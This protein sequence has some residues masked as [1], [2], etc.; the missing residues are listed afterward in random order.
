MIFKSSTLAMLIG[1]ALANTAH[2]EQAQDTNNKLSTYQHGSTQAQTDQQSSFAKAHE[3][4]GVYL[5]ILSE[6][7][8]LDSTYS[9]QGS[10]RSEVVAVIEQQQ[11]DIM[12]AIRNLDANAVLTRKARLTENALYV[13]MTHEAAK[14]IRE[15][16]R[17]ILAELLNEEPNYTAEDEFARF[18]FLN[19]K[20]AGDAVT[21]AII[22][23]GID[24]THA[25][26]GGEGTVEAYEQAWA[27][28]HNAWDG[29]PTDTVIGGLDFG[30]EGY[31]YID[32]NPLEMAGDPNVESGA[33]PSGTVIASQILEQAPDAKILSYKTYD[34]SHAYFYP[35]L[36][37]IV[38]P[39]QDGDIS[40]RP[41]VI[42]MNAWGNNAFYVE[43]DTQGSQPTRD[44]G[45]VRRL[46]ATGSLLVV[47][48]GQTYYDQYFNLAWRGAVPEALT[49][50][51]VSVDGETMQLSDFTPAGPVRGG[52]L[53]KPE[54]VG[55]GE[56]I[57][58]PLAGSGADNLMVSPHSSYAAGY[59]A[60]TAARILAQ[61][62]QLSPIEAKALVANTANAE[63]IVGNTAY[64]EEFDVHTHKL[65]EVPFMGTGMVDGE[66]AVTANAVAFESSSYQPGLAFGFV[67]TATKTSV[68]RYVTLKNL[69]H[70]VQSYTIS[71]MVN[72][73]KTNNAAVSFVYPEVVN[74]PGNRSVS[75]PVTM[76]LD[77]SKLATDPLMST[78]DFTIE[79]WSKASVNG[80]L[81]FTSTKHNAAD[82]AMAWQV[83]PKS[84]A[85]LSK[86]NFGITTRLPYDGG[87][88]VE[89]SNS[90][91]EWIESSL[92]DVTNNTAQ[93]RVLHTLPS[94][95]TIPVKEP[96]KAGGQ[97]HLYKRMG[98]TIS[99]DD[100]CESNAMLSMAVQMFD[101]FDVPVAEHFDKAGHVLSYFSIYSEAITEQYADDPFALDRSATDADKLAYFEIITVDSGLP[102]LKY[103]DYSLEFRW[104]DP[105]YRVKY[106]EFPVDV[107]IGDDT[108]VG[109]ICVEDLYH[110]DYQSVDAF[111]GNLG[112]QFASDRDAQS[113]VSGNVI[114]YN[115]MINGQYFEEIVDHTGETGYPNWWDTWT[116]CAAKSWDP[117][118]CIENKSTLLA[119]TGKIATLDDEGEALSWSNR[120]E[121]APGETV[122][123]S[124]GASLQC[125]PNVVSTGIWVTHEDCPEGVMIF[126]TGND[127]FYMSGATFGYD[128]TVIEGQSFIVYENAENG[129][130]VGKV[131]MNSR[132]F[133]Q[134]ETADGE[135]YLVNAIPG[136]PFSVAI[137]GTISVANAD[138]INYEDNTSFTLKL[139]ADYVNRDSKLVEVTVI[140]NN[141]NDVAPMQVKLTD[142]IITRVGDTVNVDLNG[143]FVDVEGDGVAYYSD[144][145]PQGL[146]ISASGVIS[147]SAEIAGNYDATIVATDGANEATA[148]VT[149]EVAQS[150]QGS[151]K[152]QEQ[153]QEEIAEESDDSS[154]GSTSFVFALLTLFGL[155]S[156]RVYK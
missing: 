55:P 29:F 129:A 97:G 54:V 47:G 153:N 119:T 51:T 96:S 120:K 141:V 133:F 72:G 114:R 86:D 130:V 109:H 7:S 19:V 137:D 148:Q 17:V 20:D 71:Q 82:L 28:R 74:V 21:V 14:T 80:Y 151:D 70:K 87:K 46:S 134:P 3:T 45:L 33:L 92:V 156:R 48:A 155:I 124:A 18:P 79:N 138:A 103:I 35:V 123:V 62:P 106:S 104:W 95:V 65:A 93:T 78:E 44:I 42:V 128:A 99:A 94:I 52:H 49:V 50:G 67:E 85:E 132:N 13:Q 36:D 81:T 41:D 2:A 63:G 58:G 143:T 101:K 5:F 37:V 107:S 89:L 57:E 118:Y 91:G 24:Y 142:S 126:E 149:V 83:F 23:N 6:K 152:K 27:N 110:H 60:G 90:S 77:A 43:G 76:T 1:A 105:L 121:I 113:P 108:A 15:D 11:Q 100:R 32:Y 39:N 150:A 116:P 84:S 146:T 61:Y 122:R 88:M 56:N 135:I 73:E 111:D 112:W 75:F 147:G 64:I 59:A 98:A 30:A 68:T 16:S 139:Q 144:N 12:A 10:D 69:T 66:N 4:T 40:D 53:L 125:N 115:P 127:Q 131:D 31:H 145:L 34:W 9:A 154:A 102:K 25:A 117:D 8:A 140:V 26:L 22:A 38:D 136:T